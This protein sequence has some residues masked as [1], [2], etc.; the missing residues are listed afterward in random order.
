M[1]NWRLDDYDQAGKEYPTNRTQEDYRLD[2]AHDMKGLYFCFEC[3]DD[4][5][6]GTG[7]VVTRLADTGSVMGVLEIDVEICPAC[8]ENEERGA[9]A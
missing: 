5:K 8:G 7:M 2:M 4:F 6:Q 9:A 1:A 3:G